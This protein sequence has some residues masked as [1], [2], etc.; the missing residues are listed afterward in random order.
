M[1]NDTLTVAVLVGSLRRDSLNRKLF[2]AT[3]G[4]APAGMTLV[5]APIRHLPL[6]DED[7][8]AAP[9]A[10]VVDF[11]RIIEGA[12]GVLIISPEY[13]HSIP[14]P[15]KNA[16][17]WGSRKSTNRAL[18]GKPTAIMGVASGLSGTIRA[19]S[20]LRQLLATLNMPGLT[21]N[22]VVVRDGAS[23]FDESG[24]LVD[25]QVREH[26]GKNLAAFADWIRLLQGR[27]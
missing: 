1:P 3:H 25:D 4:L 18:V 9:P 26:V 7:L 21:T 27:N 22:D 6:F 5:E 8:E 17:D 24:A 11:Q 16:I 14:G 12:D 19:Q 10:E 20:H 13:N 23:K 15:L 2:A